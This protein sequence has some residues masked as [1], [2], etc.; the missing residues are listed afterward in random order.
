VTSVQSEFSSNLHFSK[1]VIIKENKNLNCV[2]IANVDQDSDAHK[3]GIHVGDQLLGVC[4]VSLRGKDFESTV[5]II[6]ECC[7]QK[8]F[9]SFL[10]QYNPHILFDTSDQDVPTPIINDDLDEIFVLNNLTRTVLL[11]TALTKLGMLFISFFH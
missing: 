7:R 1:G 11:K 10:V 6:S 5:Q 2:Y 9:I 8:T 4:D 3:A